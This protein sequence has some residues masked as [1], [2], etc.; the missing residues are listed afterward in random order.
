MKLSPRRLWIAA[1][2][3]LIPI[4]YAGWRQY[5]NYLWWDAYERPIVNDS[6]TVALPDGGSVIYRNQAPRMRLMGPADTQKLLRWQRPDGRSHDYP[7]SNGGGGYRDLELR[8]RTDGKAL[9]LISWDWKKIV[10]T[11]DLKTG[12]FTGEGGVAYNWNVDGQDE[13]DSAEHPKWAKMNA[14]RSLG[15]HKF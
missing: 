3:L 5:E 4:T 8:L 10:A 9:W 13:S 2:L 6:W 1:L 15:H 14:G 11:L 12:R 7:I